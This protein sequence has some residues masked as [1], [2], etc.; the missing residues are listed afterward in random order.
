MLS[1]RGV[2]LGGLGMKRLIMF[3]IEYDLVFEFV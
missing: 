1:H 3:R 2:D